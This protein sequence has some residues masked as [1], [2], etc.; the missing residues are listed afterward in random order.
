MG[1]NALRVAK[2]AS[3]ISWAAL[4]GVVAVVV[5]VSRLGFDRRDGEEGRKLL[6]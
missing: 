4:V 3:N 6:L 1:Y 5:K 2:Y